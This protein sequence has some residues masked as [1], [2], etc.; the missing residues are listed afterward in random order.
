MCIQYNKSTVQ[1]NCEMSKKRY[2]V[3]TFIKSFFF[4]GKVFR[5]QQ[6]RKLILTNSPESLTTLRSLWIVAQ[7]LVQPL[8]VPEILV[9]CLQSK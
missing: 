7:W 2:L 9:C 3:Q 1:H 6:E 8:F 4:L 5:A